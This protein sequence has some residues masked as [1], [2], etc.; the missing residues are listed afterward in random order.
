MQELDRQGMVVRDIAAP[1]TPEQ[2]AAKEAA[3]RAKHVQ[4]DLE[5]E[6]QRQDKALLNAYAS[7]QDIEVARNRSLAIP[8]EFI[9]SA[10]DRLADLLKER[11]SNQQEA[12]N[13]NGK[14][15]P[16]YL[17]RHMD[18]TE[19]AIT[20]DQHTI[21]DRRA[22]MDRLNLKYDNEIAR[23]RLLTKKNNK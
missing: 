18:Q 16:P 15:L 22:E 8:Q 6:Q 11:Q 19:A 14:P 1:L 2:Q 13:F 17:Q 4:E 20:A 12:G 5:R 3:D 21:N 10:N 23:F 9:R 7:E